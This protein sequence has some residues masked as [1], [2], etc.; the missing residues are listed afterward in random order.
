MPSGSGSGCGCPTTGCWPASV[1][2][3]LLPRLLGPGG[4]D[5]GV[6]A[7]ELFLCAVLANVAYT[8]AYLVDIPVQLSDFRDRWRRWRI[9]LFVIGTA[10]AAG[11]AWLTGLALFG[12]RG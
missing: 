3:C 8:T 7:L 9:G 5:G 4:L 12:C 2:Y 11:L 1:G 10:F 6:V